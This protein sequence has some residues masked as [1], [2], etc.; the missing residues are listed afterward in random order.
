VKLGDITKLITK[1]TTPTT[2]GF[3]FELEGVAFIKVE[4]ISVN[5]FVDNKMISFISRECHESL[6]RSQ[7][8]ENDILFSIDGTEMGVSA[9]VTKNALPVNT[10]QALTL[11][12]LKEDIN[13][14]FALNYLRSAKL[15]IQIERI[16]VNIAQFNLSLKQVSEIEIPIAPLAVQYKIIAEIEAERQAFDGYLDL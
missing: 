5:G 7:L 11:I 16:K 14:N 1:G 12:R 13:Q 15:Q 6:T 4:S 8:M 3:M 10:N 9:L 2:Y